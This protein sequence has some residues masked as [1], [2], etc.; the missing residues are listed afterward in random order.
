M[1]NSIILIIIVY[2]TFSC[3]KSLEV[4]IPIHQTKPVIYSLFETGKRFE[5]KINKSVGI[6]DEFSAPL[7][8]A[9][10]YLLKNGIYVDTLTLVDNSYISDIIA[11]ENQ[12]Y[13]IHTIIPG[14]GE[15]F[16][17]NMAPKKPQITASNIYEVEVYDEDIFYDRKLNFTIEDIPYEENYYEVNLAT[18][19]VNSVTQEE[20]IL[21]LNGQKTN[22][23]IIVNEGILEYF[24]ITYVFSDEMFQDTSVNMSFYYLGEDHQYLPN[25]NIGDEYRFV[26]VLRNTSKEYYTYKKKL[27][28]HLNN[29]ESD[30]WDGFGE[31]TQMY[32]NIENGYGIFAGYSELQE[33]FY[34]G[35]KE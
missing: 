15:Q 24:P 35:I 32:T 14:F 12:A 26:I 5:V 21:Y 19:Y 17:S 20:D 18:K 33:V 2:I 13:S 1:K 30:V 29:Q 8:N 28:Q 27:F 16:A 23:P 22:D 11:E 34:T 7:E 10:V 25:L 4:D 3:T 6:L 9:N 31:P